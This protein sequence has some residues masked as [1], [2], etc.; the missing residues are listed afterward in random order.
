MN[1][2]GVHQLH[3]PE[4]STEMGA[5]TDV[6]SSGSKDGIECSIWVVSFLVPSLLVAKSSPGVEVLEHVF[7]SIGSQEV[8]YLAGP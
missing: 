2:P 1:N 7:Y 3:V 6:V 4:V 5:S 8:C